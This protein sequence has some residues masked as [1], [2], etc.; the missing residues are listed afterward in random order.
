M[1]QESPIVPPTEDGPRDRTWVVMQNLVCLM[2]EKGLLSRADVE[3][4]CA[5]VDMAVE[6][7]ELQP[8]PVRPEAALAAAKGMHELNDYIGRRYGGK[9]RREH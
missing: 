1:A 4:L 7:P 2:R 9:H 8:K 5:K 6:H 3:E